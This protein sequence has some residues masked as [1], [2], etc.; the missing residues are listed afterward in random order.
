MKLPDCK[1]LK[2]DFDAGVLYLS[3][4][5]PEKRNAM[6][7]A[8]V[9]ELLAV[10]DSISGDRTVRAVVM[11]GRGGHFCAGGDISGMNID[12]ANEEQASARTW[13][14]NRVFGEMITRVNSAPQVVIALL[15]GAVLGGG[16][17][18]ACVSDVAIVDAGAKLSMPETGLG[19]IPAQIAPFVVK[20]IGLTQA[21]RLALLG[22]R[23][24]GEAACDLGIAHF[25]TRSGREMDMLL[26]DLLSRL[27]RCAPGA[28]AM[29]K[30][31]MLQVDSLELGKLLDH[32][33]DL[34]T[35]SMR[36]GE[37]KEGTSAFLEKRRPAWAVETDG[38]DRR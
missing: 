31:L 10:F 33:A 30:G 25:L 37:G 14:F 28:N 22:E 38:K 1:T 21:R 2:L 34:F 18:L 7:L 3:L 24:D 11:R 19:I 23:L 13:R 16:L 26:Q 4:N 20:R 6:N 9:E 27:R 17:G 32:A 29:T 15:E 5:R 36:K 35:E 12:E 8:M